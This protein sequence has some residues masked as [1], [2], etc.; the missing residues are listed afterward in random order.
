MNNQTGARGVAFDLLQAVL[1]RHRPLDEAL[2]DHPE[3]GGLEARDRAFARLLVATALRRLGSID[4]LIDA[5]LRTPLP[6][7][8]MPVRDALR[9]GVAQLVFL[10]TPP[11]A[12]VDTTVAQVG[13]LGFEKLKG[14]ANAV[15]RRIAGQGRDGSDGDPER[16]T[17]DWLWQGWVDAYGPATA[18]GI[19]AAHRREPPLDLTVRT[20][21]AGWAEKLGAQLLPTGSLRLAQAGDPTAL[22]GYA[23][24]AW[25]V[26]DAAA[27]LPARLL[28]PIAGRPVIDLCAAPGGKTAQL[29]AAG[30]Q[31]TAVDRSA[32][33]MATL[34][35]N[36]VRLGL[37]AE[38]VVADAAEWRPAEP[39]AALLLDAPCSATGTIRRHPDIA[40]LKRRGDMPR[41]LETQDRLLAAAAEMLRPGGVLVYAV[42]SL[43]PAEGPDRIA[44]FLAGG[45]PFVR[46]PVRPEEAPALE[47]ALD[48]NGGLRTLPCHWQAQ[49]GLDGFYI[50]RLRRRP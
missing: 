39:A 23:E 15:L 7:Q 43:E 25:W 11:H 8:A 2:S 32:R 6:R 45:A 44:A 50:A 17:P 35:A 34:Q 48:G 29:A 10:G 31:V 4:A 24:G 49:G 41:I 28:G 16:D 5:R 33:R 20:D 1:R 36:L 3:I 21:P 42:C 30:A 46:D 38:T 47:E 40:Y 14:L 26:Q 22:P 27:A 9:L 18:A 13:A 19:A 12:A 37:G